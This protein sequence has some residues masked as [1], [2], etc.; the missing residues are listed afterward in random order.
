M[1]Y[2]NQDKQYLIGSFK[3]DGIIPYHVLDAS[4]MEHKLKQQNDFVNK[5]KRNKREKTK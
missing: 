5:T 4:E 1:K 3:W 2:A